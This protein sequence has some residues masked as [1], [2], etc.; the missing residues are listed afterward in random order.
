M[1]ALAKQ[2]DLV[3]V[4]GCRDAAQLLFLLA[5]G[6]DAYQG[7]CSPRRALPTRSPVPREEGV[8][9]RM[10]AARRQAS[11]AAAAIR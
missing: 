2:R 6:C 10:T 9:L 3:S 11:R 4:A 5:N 1:I 8:R 7:H